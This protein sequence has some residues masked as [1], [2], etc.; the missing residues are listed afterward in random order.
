MHTLSLSSFCLQRGFCWKLMRNAKNL[1]NVHYTNSY[2]CHTQQG[3]SFS[4]A[5]TSL[6][7]SDLKRTLTSC[8]SQLLYRLKVWAAMAFFLYIHY[9]ISIYS[10]YSIFTI[11]T[12]VSTRSLKKP[13]KMP[14]FPHWNVI[15]LALFCLPLFNENWTSLSHICL[16]QG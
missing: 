6:I 1:S 13:N 14:F 15:S 12:I 4:Q 5:V 7:P 9:I 8:S 2:L 16:P 11:F 10:L 3:T